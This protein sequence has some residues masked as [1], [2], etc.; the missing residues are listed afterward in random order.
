LNRQG[1]PRFTGLGHPGR[2]VRG[3]FKAGISPA[4]PAAPGNDKPFLFDQIFNKITGLT[5][6]DHGSRRYLNDQIGTIAACFL[7][8]LTGRSVFGLEMGFVAKMVEGPFAEVG[9]NNNA[10]ALAAVTTVRP[11]PGD[12]FF[13]PEADTSAA[14]RSGSYCNFCRVN[15]FHWT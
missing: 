1:L 10:A 2:T 12:E 8:A 5:V 15:K 3:R 7:A 13:P 6:N 11:P 9:G 4:A 14:A